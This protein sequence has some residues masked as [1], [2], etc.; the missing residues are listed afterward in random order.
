MIGTEGWNPMVD[1][2]EQ[3]SIGSRSVQQ[4][5]LPRMSKGASAAYPAIDYTDSDGMPRS[6]PHPLSVLSNGL[7]LTHT[8]DVG[9]VGSGDL[10]FTATAEDED[11]EAD[12]VPLQAHDAE[13]GE[14]LWDFGEPGDPLAFVSE[15][16]E[17][18]EDGTGVLMAETGEYTPSA[19]IPDRGS[20][21]M[22]LRMLDDQGEELW[23]AETAAIGLTDF[24]AVDGERYL[25]VLGDIIVVH[26]GP[27][28]VSA[29][30]VATGEVL[31]S[32]DE[33]DEETQ[34]LWL[35]QAFQVEDAVHLPGHGR[36]YLV[37]AQTGE[38][39]GEGAD[40]MEKARVTEFAEVGDDFVLVQ[41]HDYGYTLMQRR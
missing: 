20:V 28:E 8:Y 9:T 4:V 29:L 21:T 13:T 1:D 40:V 36:E 7:Y 37:D 5:Q 17:A 11:I 32:I 26:T 16:P 38:P 14:A 6:R 24:P 18:V 22:T 19:D 35:H 12:L 33:T 39:V 30:D 15:V 41:T 25:G 2:D 3:D 23:E 34:P 31:W 10:W 27:H